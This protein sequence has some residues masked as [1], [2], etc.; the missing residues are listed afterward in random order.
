MKK[1]I[2]HINHA[3]LAKGHS[4]MYVMHKYWAR[5]PHNIIAKYLEAYTKPGDIVLDAFSGSG[6]TVI[7]AVRRGRKGI[8]IDINPMGIFITQQTLIKVDLEKILVIFKKIS[9]DV[10]AEIEKLYITSCPRCKKKTFF[11]C[12]HWKGDKPVNIVLDCDSCDTR[13]KKKPDKQDKTLLYKVNREKITLFYPKFKFPRGVTFNQAR[14]EAGKDIPS[15]FTHRNLLALT[16]LFDAIN[17]IKSPLYRE[18]FRFAFT[19]MLHLATKLTPV[20]PSRQA[21][22]FWATHSYWVPDLFMESNVW[23]LFKSAVKGRQ[24]LI[25]AKKESNKEIGEIKRA[26]TFNELNDGKHYLIKTMSILDIDS[27]FPANSVDY[28][29]TDPPYGGIIPYLE[30]STL[31]A[32][33][34]GYKLQFEE[35]ITINK[36]QDKNFEYYYKMMVASFRQIRRV[37]KKGAYMT[38]TFHNSDIKIFNFIIRAAIFAGLNLEKII[39][40]PPVRPSAMGLLRPYGSATGD[41]YLRFQK[42][43]KIKTLQKEK[44]FGSKQYERIV[45]QTTK[46]VLAQ[47]G[48]PTFFDHIR[49]SVYVELHKHGVFF[50]GEES[51]EKVLNQHLGKEFKLVETKDSGTNKTAGKK[52]WFSDPSI[53]RF[54]DTTPIADRVEKVVLNILNRDIKVSFDEVLQQIFIKFPNALTPDTQSVIR[55]LEEYSVKTKDGKWQLKP[56]VKIRESEHSK[57]MYYLAIIGKKLNF[58]VVTGHPEAQFEKKRLSEITKE[59]KKVADFKK[60]SIEAKNINRIKNIDVLWLEKGII[61]YIFEV[62]NTTSITESLVRATNIPYETVRCLVIPEERERF[63]DTKIK[64]P[65]F[66]EHLKDN[67]WKIIFY[68]KLE[69]FIKSRKRRKFLVSDFISIFSKKGKNKIEDSGQ[70]PL[71]EHS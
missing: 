8:G 18:Q 49:N 58:D 36:Y 33:W 68:T 71:I 21:S 25:K 39:Y 27:I 69:E 2:K 61:K 42:P 26:K 24:G 11:I 53:I 35:E 14:S 51:I 52:W 60:F 38:L 50:E 1:K 13:Y 9:N 56:I 46:S 43:R 22:S 23:N 29:F 62:E 31:W 20:R 28:V 7:E 6:V 41:F 44:D 40:Q 66:A 65:M 45:V 4:P 67:P 64:E 15:L 16:I 47:R 55:V 12:S 5:K 63:L 34:L 30:L 32:T 10:K 37:L 3:L 57:M 59:I 70:L 17:N 48:E 19:S 54:L